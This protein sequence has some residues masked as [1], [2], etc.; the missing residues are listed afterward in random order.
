MAI[1]IAFLQSEQTLIPF[2]FVLAIIFGVLELTHVFRN[3]G[4]NFLIAL[5]ISFFT[6]SNTA[7]VNA[8]WSYFGVITAFFIFMFFIAFILE[9]FGFR[10]PKHPQ[11]SRE[12]GMIVIGAILLLLLTFGF[13]YS[14]MIPELPFIGGGSNVIILFA[15][16]F[17]LVIFWMAFKVGREPLP[18]KEE[19]Q[20]R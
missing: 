13:M 3:R 17:I 19:H 5:A 2:L 14:S 1:D 11:E 16:I 18:M 8:L 4:V 20:T 9:V 15:I 10:K 12:E 6:I 7:F